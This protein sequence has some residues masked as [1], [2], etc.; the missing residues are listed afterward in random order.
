MRPLVTLRLLLTALMVLLLPS[1]RSIGFDYRVR[2]GFTRPEL[3]SVSTFVNCEPNELE[4][5]SAHLGSPIPLKSNGFGLET[6]LNETNS[7]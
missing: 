5:G 1:W 2:I 6:G 4:M 7:V 3:K